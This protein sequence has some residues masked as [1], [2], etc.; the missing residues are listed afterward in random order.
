MTRRLLVA[1]QVL[2]SRFGVIRNFT[3]EVAALLLFFMAM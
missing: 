3:G 1:I 2:V